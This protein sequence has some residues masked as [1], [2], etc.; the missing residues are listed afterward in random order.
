VHD[1]EDY[2]C[3]EQAEFDGDTREY[4]S[5]ALQA[6]NRPLDYEQRDYSCLRIARAS[7]LSFVEVS[8]PF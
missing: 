1:A 3:G 7:P 8:L 6:G 4:N 2:G 5:S